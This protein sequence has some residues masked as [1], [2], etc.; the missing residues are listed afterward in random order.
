[1]SWSGLKKAVNRASAHVMMK[2]KHGEA[3]VDPE[4]DQREASFHKFEGLTAELQIDLSSF[5]DN[6][7]TLLETQLNIVK[8][9]DS[10]YGDYDFDLR[11]DKDGMV[12][13]AGG[14]GKT[15]SR[16]GISLD[17]LKALEEVKNLVLPEL[18]EPLQ[19]TVM[20]PVAELRSYNEEIQQLIRK[21]G[22]KKFDY[23][24]LRTKLN[25]LQRSAGAEPETDKLVHHMEKLD[26]LKREFAQSESVYVEMNGRLK[27]E[28]DEY[29]ALRFSLLDPTF[30]AFVKIQVKLYTDLYNTLAHIHPDAASVQEYHSSQLDERLD[31]I[32]AKMKSLDLLNMA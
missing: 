18:L 2:A 29:L 15:N 1:M 8:T 3:S 9:I 6:F 13:V 23:D 20:D 22:R 7:E 10:F 27:T 16:D 5:I 19:V 4:F 11:S 24:V 32:L 30:E 28:I 12:P 31:E 21:R 17:Y 25:K 14:S 26:Q